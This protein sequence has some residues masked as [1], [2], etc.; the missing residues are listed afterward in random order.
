VTISTNL[1]CI[2]EREN[3]ELAANYEKKRARGD[4]LEFSEEEKSLR[5]HALVSHYQ[6]VVSKAYS[7]IILWYYFETILLIFYSFDRVSPFTNMFVR[8]DRKETIPT[9]QTFTKTG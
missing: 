2:V 3:F 9:C 6:N 7:V 5:G 4:Y 8:W 1:D